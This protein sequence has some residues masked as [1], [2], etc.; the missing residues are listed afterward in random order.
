MKSKLSAALAA[1]CVMALSVGAAKANS[2]T[3][4]VS[5]TFVASGSPACLNCTLGGTITIDTDSGSVL[6][7][8][9]TVAG[10]PKIVGPFT[11]N[12]GP[13]ATGIGVVGLPMADGLGDTANLL[14]LYIDGFNLVGYTGGSICSASS[15]CGGQFNLITKLDVRDPTTWFLESG[16]LTPEAAAVPGP[17]AGAGLPGLMLAGVGLL[18]WW[19]RKRKAEAAA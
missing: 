9:V 6:A 18:G 12:L 1:G 19:R 16:S 5:G 14:Y 4:D 11:V 17:I 13:F 8:D 3:F 15:P 10:E 7:E 2:V